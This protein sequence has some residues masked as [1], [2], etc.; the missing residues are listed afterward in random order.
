[1]KKLDNGD[2]SACLA[3]GGGGGPSPAASPVESP[4]SGNAP[5]SGDNSPT[6]NVTPTSGEEDSPTSDSQPTNSDNND[7]PTFGSPDSWP[8]W[9]GGDG[10]DSPDSWPTWS[11]RD[12]EDSPTSWC[13]WNRALRGSV[14]EEEAAQTSE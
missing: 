8:T 14:K 1:M 2:T 5:T 13:W 9:S 11:S 3:G 12:D 6:F 7:S 10:G 4:N